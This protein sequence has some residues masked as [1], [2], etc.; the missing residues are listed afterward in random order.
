[1]VS[2]CISTALLVL[3]LP[4]DPM[5]VLERSSG[6]EYTS[7]FLSNLS[8]VVVPSAPSRH[9]EISNIDSIFPTLVPSTLVNSSPSCTS[10]L[11]P[12]G[13]PAITLRTIHAGLPPSFSREKS[14]PTPHSCLAG[15]ALPPL[16]LA[17]GTPVTED[18]LGR[19]T[20]APLASPPRGIDATLRGL[21]VRGGGEGAA[22]PGTLET[23]PLLGR[24]WW[25]ADAALGL[26]GGREAMA[27]ASWAGVEAVVDLMEAGRRELRKEVAAGAGSS[28]NWAGGEPGAMEEGRARSALR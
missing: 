23:E 13:D 18:A 19:V 20:E 16:G 1:M 25:R 14:S 4:S 22:L 26:A 12:A 24:S 11:S 27:G 10:P 5:K 8:V 15:A 6:T 28:G 17:G 9:F 2:S 7:P 21:P 3:L